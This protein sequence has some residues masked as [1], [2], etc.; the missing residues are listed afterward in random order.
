MPWRFDPDQT[1][2]DDV[3]AG[4]ED[5]ENAVAAWGCWRDAGAQR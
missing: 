3:E 1:D 4:H 5:I 2:V